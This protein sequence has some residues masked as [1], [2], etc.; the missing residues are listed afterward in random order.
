[1]D[2]PRKRLKISMKKAK[3]DQSGNGPKIPLNV[4]YTET[5]VLRRVFKLC[6]AFAYAAA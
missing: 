1:V 6:K 2:I 3:K 5:F 4:L